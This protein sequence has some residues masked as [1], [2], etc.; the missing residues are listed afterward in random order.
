M[1]I[2]YKRE[3]SVGL[4]VIV[5]IA[6]FFAS[7]AWLKGRD[8]GT[9]AS[10]RI[11]VQMDDVTG[12]KEAD[13]VLI[14]GVVVGRVTSVTLEEPGRVMVELVVVQSAQP[15]A[16]AS[17]RIAMFDFFGAQ[18]IE[19]DPGT[20][21]DMLAP[22]QVLVGTKEVP[23]MSNAGALADQAAE[24]LTGL[25]RLLSEET[26]VSMQATMSAAQEALEMVARF[27]RTPVM[28][29]ATQAMESLQGVAARLDSIT[30]NPAIDRSV[31]RLDA[32]TQNMNDMS[33]GLADI[34]IALSSIVTKIDSGQGSLGQL[35]N[36]STI[37]MDAH[38]VLSS[39]RLLL[40]DI[41]ERPGRYVHVKASVF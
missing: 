18:K 23:I 32:I 36:D 5:G 7:L 14:S 8:F 10:S 25:Q 33:A 22:G 24:V 13:P 21:T 35:V 26:I 34:S 19:Y 12:L 37:A 17:V 20:S 16:D 3:V 6:I 15:H 38:E 40:D 4:L 2:Y 39:L 30:A 27:D 1:D 11:M 29:S 9:G 31:D 41:R 28:R